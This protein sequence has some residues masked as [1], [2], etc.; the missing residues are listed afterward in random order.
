MI[1]V[2]VMMIV[3]ESASLALQPALKDARANQAFDRVLMQLRWLVSARLRTV[4]NTLF[5]F[6]AASRP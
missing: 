2:A 4:S 1:V 3:P 5:C 6:G